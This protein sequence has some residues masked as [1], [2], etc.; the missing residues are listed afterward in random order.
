MIKGMLKS[1][2]NNLEGA[3]KETVDLVIDHVIDEMCLMKKSY[4]V[5]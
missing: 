2:E 3:N 5:Y 4:D 1:Y